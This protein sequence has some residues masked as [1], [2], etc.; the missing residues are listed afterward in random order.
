MLCLKVLSHMP[1]GALVMKPVRQPSPMRKP[2]RQPV[3]G[4]RCGSAASSAMS[5]E[6]E[7]PAVHAQLQELLRRHEQF[8]SELESGRFRGRA[9]RDV[10]CPAAQSE[11]EARALA[12][13]AGVIQDREML[14][15][16]ADARSGRYMYFGPQPEEDERCMGSL[17]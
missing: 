10:R 8:K 17:T 1:I 15:L 13:E 2:A 12:A 14:L 7:D 3:P 5:E 4:S 9:V 16:L 6:E 11:G